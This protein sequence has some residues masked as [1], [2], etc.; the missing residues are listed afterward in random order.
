MNNDNLPYNEAFIQAVSFVNHTNRH[1]FLTGKAGTGKT[2]FLR[3]IR[4]NSY[5]KMAVTAPT[6]V[7]AINAGGTTLHS[8]FHL[9]FGTYLAD[10]PLNWNEEDHF[11]Y[12]RRRLFGKVRL[13]HERR[14]LLQEIDLLV[15]DEVSMLRADML[16]A[17]DAI[18][19]NV[20]RDA[21]PFGGL[22]VLF[23]GDLYQLPPVIKQQEWQLMQQYYRSPFFFDAHV[24]EEAKPVLLELKKIYRQ[25]DELFINILNNIRNNCCTDEQLQQLN[26]YHK[27]GFSAP[28]GDSYITLTSHNALANTI[29]QRELVKL[30]GKLVKMEASI[31]GEFA[32]NAY[33]AEAAL[34]LKE[35]AQIMFIKNDKGEERRFY[36]GK[37]GHVRRISSDGKELTVV[38]PEG[39]EAITVKKE[40]WKNIRYNYDQA[41]DRIREETLGTFTQFP[42]RLAWA[43]TIHKSQGLT[44]DKAV[45]DAGASFAAGQVYVALSRVRSL[46]GLVLKSP[47]TPASIRTDGLVAQF[48]SHALT[49]DI[50]PELLES[51][52]RSYLGYILLQTFSWDKIY[53]RTSGFLDSL[54]DRNIADQAQA[55]QFISVLCTACNTL[56]EVANKFRNQLSGLLQQPDNTDY[57]AVHE[58]TEKAGQWFYKEITRLLIDPMEAH[59]AAWKIKKR[60]KKYIEE[61]HSLL[62]EYQRKREQVL[63]CSVI[64]EALSGGRPLQE[65]MDVSLTARKIKPTQVLAEEPAVPK[66]AKGETRRISLELFREGRTLEQIANSRDLTRGTVLSHLCHFIPT[67]EVHATELMTEQRLHHVVTIIKNNPGKPTGG[68]KALLGDAYDYDDIRIAQAYLRSQLATTGNQ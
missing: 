30:P 5:K 40:E 60:T 44:F 31:D 65:V 36:N 29:N 7:A 39:G 55:Y 48:S 1:I 22:Q 62:L 67:G 2:T 21:R 66:P 23:I 42:I 47:I 64:T 41:Q 20:R 4:D 9:P 10:H 6:G 46:D 33:P 38:F 34:E 68:I 8:L 3:Y 16:D 52:Q 51:S 18:L 25:S 57:Q 56:R 27:P 19:K 54:Q 35:G 26:S 49:D 45:I 61:L 32:E 13:G 24:M 37:I 58:R 43:V 11:I 28:A 50:V 63:Q 17:I 14:A 59:I 12:N 15:I 53:E